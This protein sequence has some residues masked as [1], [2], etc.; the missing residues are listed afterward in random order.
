MKNLKSKIRL[1]L[2]LLTVC[3]STFAQ[4]DSH[5]CEIVVTRADLEKCATYK[6]QN[7]LLEKEIKFQAVEKVSLKDTLK[8]RNET[9]S[10]L[11]KTNK[12]LNE[13]LE[14]W[15]KFGLTA[16]IIVILLILLIAFG[17][18]IMSKISVLIFFSSIGFAQVPEYRPPFTFNNQKGLNQKIIYDTTANKFS[19]ESANDVHILKIP[20]TKLFITPGNQFQYYRG[21]KTWQ[22]LN[23]TTVGLSNVDNTSDLN[24]PISTLTQTA[25]N[26]KE[27][28]ILSGTTS[29]YYR[30]DKT[31]QTLDKSTVG[32][33]NVENTALSTWT[34]STNIATIGAATAST[35]RVGA[36]TPFFTLNNYFSVPRL[37]S[38]AA[39]DFFSTGTFS[40]TTTGDLQQ[41]R[42]TPTGLKLGSGS[43]SYKLDL[44]GDFGYQGLIYVGN[45]ARGIS[46]SSGSN[47]QFLKRNTVT[48]GYGLPLAVN[49]WANI[50]ISD[51]SGLG[52][53]ASLS[54]VSL[55]SNVTGSLPDANIASA[56]IWNAKLSGNGTSG[57]IAKYSSSNTQTNSVIFDNGVNVG[58]GTTSP[59]YKLH[60]IGNS[61]IQ[62]VQFFNGVLNGFIGPR[63]DWTGGTLNDNLAIG[64]YQSYIS[65]FT[66]N[67]VFESVR[68]DERGNVGIGTTSPAQTAILDLNS[69]SKALKLT[70]VT[71][72]QRNA[73]ATPQAGYILFNSTTGK[74]EGYDGTAWVALH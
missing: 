9:V 65:F 53:L 36:S 54:S 55:T 34:G 26:A 18:K 69:N 70:V 3:F 11:Q 24:K 49:Q 59:A 25:L 62:N 38:S 44:T 31:W 16:S 32:L 8:A 39:I 43:A 52:S 22:T 15:K 12:E 71:T 2:C 60:V 64:S 13:S 6:R 40:W 14:F 21:D 19:I 41:M 7:E 56:A 23:K 28:T 35:L 63:S 61:R 1:S 42:L 37:S 58:I 72:S 20:Y 27:N 17:P 51:V 73:I 50:G 68:I 48:D 47:G 67:S 10:T 46:M 57:Y 33:S 5:D 66:N 29:Q 4:T 45:T 30:G 74:F